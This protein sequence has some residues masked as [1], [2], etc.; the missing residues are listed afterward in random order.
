MIW[1]P[2]LSG[3]HFVPPVKL[4]NPA[5]THLDPAGGDLFCITYF[6]VL[7]KLILSSTTWKFD[8]LV[9]QQ[10]LRVPPLPNCSSKQ[11]PVGG[12]AKPEAA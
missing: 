8:F 6:Y 1:E 12:L 5:L 7:L 10:H 2:K 4:Q 9:V 3:Q 11:R